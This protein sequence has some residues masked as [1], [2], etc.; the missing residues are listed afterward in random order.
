MR[1]IQK[2]LPLSFLMLFLVGCDPPHDIDFVNLTDAEAKIKIK[3]NPKIE[4]NPFRENLES[5][6]IVF[7]LKPKDTASIYFGIGTWSDREVNE[8]VKSIE[9]IEVETKNIKTIYKTKE[10][11]SDILKENQKGL[12]WK[13]KIEI[14][15]K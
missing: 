14:G 11:I 12:W 10:S 7:N 5:D 8:V 9:T 4:P 2:L 13:T 1:N 6:S 15:I 3:I